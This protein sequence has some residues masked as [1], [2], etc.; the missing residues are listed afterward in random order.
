MKILNTKIDFDF[1]DAD[2]IEKIEKQIDMVQKEIGEVDTDKLSEAIR[3]TCTVIRKCFD[4][5]FG[6]GTA[7]KVFGDKYSLKPCIE[8]FHELIQEKIK[9]EEELN[10]Q[11][12]SF[13]QYLPER[14]KK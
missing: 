1:L 6:E 7:Q 2:N 13:S 10:K 8:A 12:N 9:Q 5:I 3:K 11:M 4:N 14:L